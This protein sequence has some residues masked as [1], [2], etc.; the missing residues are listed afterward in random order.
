MSSLKKW[1]VA[2]AMAVVTSSTCAAT[3][4]STWSWAPD[5]LA[6]PP[7]R[8][9]THDIAALGFDPTHDTITSVD[10]RLTFTDPGNLDG[11]RW[12]AG[13]FGIPCICAS[14][15]VEIASIDPEGG[16]PIIWSNVFLSPEI[17]AFTAVGQL[18]IDGPTLPAIQQ[19]GRL[20]VVVSSFTGDFRLLGS[21]PTATG[22]VPV[23]GV[24][25]LLGIGA[26]GLGAA[27]RRRLTA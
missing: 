4:T 23:P 1:T 16:I 2:A 18:F 3:W 10:L 15:G 7:T 6:V 27:A 8:T 11:I 19:D 21:T 5:G 17:G 13:L 26:V 14:D 24:L 12:C 9:F 25:A 22:S 20:D